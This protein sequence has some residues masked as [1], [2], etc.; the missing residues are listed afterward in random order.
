MNWYDNLYGLEIDISSYCN[1]EC[2]SCR[3]TWHLDEIPLVHF[4]TD[5]WERIWTQDLKGKKVQKLVLNGNWGDPGMHKNLV[6]MLDLPH[7]HNPDITLMID[8]NG[9]MRDTKFW[10]DLAQ[11]LNSKYKNS[12]VRFGIDGTDNETNDKYRVKV[13]YDKAIE[14]ARAFIDNGGMAQWKFTVFDHNVHQVQQAYK[15]AEQY[16]FF[17]F[18]SRKSYAR[19]IYDKFHTVKCTTECYDT[20]NHNDIFFMR[21]WKDRKTYSNVSRNMPTELGHE[22]P[23]Y[24]TTRV[25]ID[26]YMNVWPCCHISGELHSTERLDIKVDSWN[27]HGIKHNN[28]ANN[29]LEDVL[30]GDYF[31]QTI[32]DAVANGSWQPCRKICGIEQNV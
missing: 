11:L 9:G 14:N 24:N 6:E 29:T 27:K 5:V 31:T 21:V 26:P 20:H 10:A 7:R 4:D 3:R 25:Q 17:I 30:T 23:W 8:T 1:A 16:G 22:C 13:S 12:T 32:P 19:K 2:P 28:L 15:L 18:H